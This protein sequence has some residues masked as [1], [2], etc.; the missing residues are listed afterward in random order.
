MEEPWEKF[1]GSG[2]KGYRD[3]KSQRKQ[4]I[5]FSGNI[6]VPHKEG[7]PVGNFPRVMC[8]IKCMVATEESV[9]RLCVLKLYGVCTISQTLPQAVM[10]VCRA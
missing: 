4:C 10:F 7:R 9:K 3:Q 8:L 1:E 5:H 2:R 6:F